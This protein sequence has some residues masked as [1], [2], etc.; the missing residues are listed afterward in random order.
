MTSEATA[1]AKKAWEQILTLVANGE[2]VP[3]GERPSTDARPEELRASLI[4]AAMALDELY[5]TGSLRP[6]P[7]LR[8]VETM[9]NLLL[10]LDSLTPLPPGLLPAGDLSEVLDAIRAARRQSTL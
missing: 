3:V 8:I 10:V 1:R 9:R 5:E 4:V 2:P 6:D 7:R